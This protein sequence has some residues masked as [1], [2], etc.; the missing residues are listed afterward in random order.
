MKFL[1]IFLIAIMLGNT[2]LASAGELLFYKKTSNFEIFCIPAD[3]ATAEEI[4]TQNEAFFTQLSQDFKHTPSAPFIINIYPNLPSLHAALGWLVAP[5]W[6]IARTKEG[7]DTRICPNTPNSPY[8]PRERLMQSY[9]MGL[10]TLFLYS[11]FSTA[12]ELPR[13]LMQG[14]ALYKAGWFTAQQ[15]KQELDQDTE[16]LPDLEQLETV[17]TAGFAKL[18]GFHVSFSLVDFLVTQWGWESALM[19]LDDY[20]NFENIVNMTKQEFKLLWIEYLTKK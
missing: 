1:N 17:G 4:L 5:N 2:A 6:V 9:K 13:W 20:K 10:T 14:I 15:C 18:N 8:H 11:K 16:K 19:L 12:T 3:Q 7:T